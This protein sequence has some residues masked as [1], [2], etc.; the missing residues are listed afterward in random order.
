MIL[1]LGIKGIETTGLA[2]RSSRMTCRTDSAHGGNR[3]SP[4]IQ[5][6]YH[7]FRLSRN[8]FGDRVVSTGDYFRRLPGG[9]RRPRSKGFWTSI[10]E[11]GIQDTG[12]KKDE[13]S[14]HQAEFQGSF[15]P[16]VHFLKPSF[17]IKSDRNVPCK[18]AYPAVAGKGRM[19][20]KIT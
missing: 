9:G 17:Q 10:G 3:Q 1:V 8:A 15:Y 2:K 16:F 5:G 13:E 14:K 7:L 11:G 4:F 20:V 6:L 12:Q 18:P 19:P